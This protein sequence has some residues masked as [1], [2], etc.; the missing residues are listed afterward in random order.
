MIL[1]QTGAMF[2]DRKQP[3]FGGRLG[4]LNCKNTEVCQHGQEGTM[5]A[6]QDTRTPPGLFSDAISA[7]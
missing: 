5:M 2:S 1:G 3:A 7:R 6:T 4:E